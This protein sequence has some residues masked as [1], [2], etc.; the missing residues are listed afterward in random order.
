MTVRKSQG[1]FPLAVL[2]GIF[3]VTA[4]WSDC[5]LRTVQLAPERP[6]HRLGTPGVSLLGKNCADVP[7]QK[8]AAFL[9]L[10]LV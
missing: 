8:D 3:P 4:W 9:L 7:C 5:I 2:M 1:Q 10:L 6:S